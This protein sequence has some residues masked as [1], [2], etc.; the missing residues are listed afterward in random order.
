MVFLLF[1]PFFSGSQ[2][3]MNATLLVLSAMHVFPSGWKAQA[4][5]GTPILTSGVGQD[6]GLVCMDSDFEE[7]D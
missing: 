4:A 3:G 6:F 7:L 2:K 1:I 5:E